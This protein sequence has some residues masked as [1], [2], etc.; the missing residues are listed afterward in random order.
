MTKNLFFFFEKFLT[1]KCDQ[2][3]FQKFSK[4]SK[5][6]QIYHLAF[7]KKKFEV[8]NFFEN[9]F[10]ENWGVYD[11]CLKSLGVLLYRFIPKIAILSTWECFLALFGPSRGGKGQTKGKQ[12]NSWQ[13]KLPSKKTY[14]YWL[15]C[16]KK[17]LLYDN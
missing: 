1:S 12:T 7:S 5:I 4:K 9:F 15:L 6:F 10:E 8:T 16:K 3:F 13:K 17:S 11:R 14:E 2:N